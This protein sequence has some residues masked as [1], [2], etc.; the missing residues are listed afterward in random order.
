[1][2]YSVLLLL[3]LQL[4][5]LGLAENASQ[6]TADHCLE[7]DGTCADTDEMSP[8]LDGPEERR[9]GHHWDIE[10]EEKWK[11]FGDAPEEEEDEDAFVYKTW[12]RT[13]FTL[14]DF[15][16]NGINLASYGKQPLFELY[17]DFDISSLVRGD[18]EWEE[19]LSYRN[20]L[21]RPSLSFYVDKVARKRWLPARGYPQPKVYLLKYADELMD[22]QSDK[23]EKDVILEALPKTGSFCA[24]PTHMSLTKV[25]IVPMYMCTYIRIAHILMMSITAMV[26]SKNGCFLTESSM[27]F[28]PV[29]EPGWWITRKRGL[30]DSV[31]TDWNWP[32]M[33]V[34]SMPE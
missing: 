2:K 17:H 7:S 16:V 5:C 29:R 33:T 14:D 12:D 31:C 26:T 15:S 28:L 23:A 25:S 11:G 10:G 13:E 6:Q 27:T 22:S 34:N 20:G 8:P 1:M 32:I 3:N 19:L 21:T 24:K 9:G 4:L 18:E 30:L